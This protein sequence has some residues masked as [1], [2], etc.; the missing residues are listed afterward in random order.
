MKKLEFACFLVILKKNF[1]NLKMS[2]TL[3]EFIAI[4]KKQQ[5]QQ[6]QQQNN[7]EAVLLSFL[8]PSLLPGTFC[9]SCETSLATEC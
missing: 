8:L 6:Q 5:Q 2:V 9:F 3:V 7:I 4:K 1:S